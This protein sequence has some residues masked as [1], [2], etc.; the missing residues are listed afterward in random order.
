MEVTL[1]T[2]EVGIAAELLAREHLE[3]HGLTWVA[4]NVRG[5]ESLEEIDL[6]MRDEAFLVFIEVRSRK[7]VKYGHPLESITKQKQQR[8][9]KA[10]TVYLIKNR[11]YDKIACRF[12]VVSLTQVKEENQL[13]WIKDAFRAQY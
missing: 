13:V 3:Q 5:E 8:I 1:S 7:M 6:I 12:D 11:I 4:S 9:I 10:A 2:R